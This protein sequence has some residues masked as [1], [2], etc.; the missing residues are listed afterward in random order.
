VTV[1]S[2]VE[3]E[4]RYPPD[5]PYVASVYYNRLRRGMPLQADPT[6]A[7]ALGQ[8]R[9]LYERDYQVQSPYNTY[10]ITGL[11]PGPIGSPSSAS[12]RAALHP[13]VTD[14]FYFVARSDGKHV[15][16]RTYREHLR[17]IEAVRRAQ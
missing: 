6:V 12:L 1:A 13:A 10:L 17:A 11:P 4:V 16:S 9:R 2:I 8:R 15:F 14:F 3:A 7:Y 5:R